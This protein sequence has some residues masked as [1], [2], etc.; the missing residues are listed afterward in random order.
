MSDSSF[1]RPPSPKPRDERREGAR[2]VELRAGEPEAEGDAARSSERPLGEVVAFPGQQR[3]QKRRRPELPEPREPA[4]AAPAAPEEPGEAEVERPRYLAS[5]LLKQDWYPRTPLARSLRWGAL[6]VGSVGA[7]ALLALGA[8]SPGALGLAGILAACAVLGALPVAAQLRG[9]ALAALGVSGTGLAGWMRLDEGR[10]PAAPLLVACI[11]LT[12]S[13]LFYRAAHRTARFARVLVAVGLGATA[14][15]LVLTGGID[16]LVVETFVWHDWLFP[17][18]RVLLGLVVVVSLLT[19]L[20]PTGHGGAWAAGGAL[21]V[22]LTLEMAASL[23]SSAW[24]AAGASS[25][26]LAD[27]APLATLTFPLLAALAAG[28][29]CQLW[30]MI[31]RGATGKRSEAPSRVTNH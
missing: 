5:E 27:P 1:P 3:T 13:A 24:S 18:L 25:L 16:A 20:D 12:A 10:E 28:G 21:L 6:A 31:S 15:W 19:F 17:A 7:A 30:V 2:V 14:G 11:T 23:A 22:W 9:V 4:Q 8:S 29:L 26:S